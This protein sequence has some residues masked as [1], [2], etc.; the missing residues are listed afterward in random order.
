MNQLKSSKSELNVKMDQ[1]IK[2]KRLLEVEL[3]TLRKDKKE[4]LKDKEDAEFKAAN[5]Y[6]RLEDAM[7]KITL[8]EKDIEL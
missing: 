4:L 5:N 2:D 8:L 1:L 3:S 7:K 6:S